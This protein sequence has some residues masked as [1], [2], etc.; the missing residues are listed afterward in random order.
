MLP[1]QSLLL[2]TSYDYSKPPA[3]GLTT[4]PALTPSPGAA[5]PSPV[6]D[7][8]TTQSDSL[9]RAKIASTDTTR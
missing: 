7:Q 1:S 6:S 9:N 5:Q 3:V 4:T 8:L 2:D